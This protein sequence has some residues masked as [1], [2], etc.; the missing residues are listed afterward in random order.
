M[1]VNYLR[2]DKYIKYA[3]TLVHTFIKFSDMLVHETFGL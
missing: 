1:G 2:Q 3:E